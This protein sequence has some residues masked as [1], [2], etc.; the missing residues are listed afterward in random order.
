MTS[1]SR[2]EGRFS[3]RITTTRIR[4]RLSSSGPRNGANSLPTNFRD[5]IVRID[6]NIGN[7]NSVFFRYIQ[8]AFDQTYVPTL[9]SNANYDTVNTKWTSPSKSAVVHL[10]ST[11]RPNLMNEF[12][13]S[14]STDVNT[15]HQS[16]GVSSEAGSINKPSSWSASNLFPANAS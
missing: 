6:Q 16:P 4:T 11:L 15:V 10:T 13:V 5:D 12:V 8:D 7:K 9:W 14:F 2:L 3:F 1:A